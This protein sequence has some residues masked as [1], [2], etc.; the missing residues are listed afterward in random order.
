MN[1]A[2]NAR[3]KPKLTLINWL[4]SK[5]FSRNGILINIRP[6]VIL[7]LQQQ[8]DVHMFLVFW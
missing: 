7:V 6:F 2:V 1:K 4:E 3:I 8:E 5:D